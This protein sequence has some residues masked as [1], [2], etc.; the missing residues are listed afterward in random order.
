MIR[1]AVADDDLLVREGIRHALGDEAD[2]DIVAVAADRDELL[3][4]VERESPD[5]VLTDIRMPP[6]HATEGIDIARILRTSHPGTGVIVVSLYA[7]PEYALALLES[8]AARRGYL[9]KDRLANRQQLVAAI[10]LVAAGGSAV[11][12]QVVEILVRRGSRRHGSL[13]QTLSPREHEILAEIAAGRSNR[14]IADR[15]FLSKGAVEQHVSAVFAKL[16]LPREAEVSRRVVATLLFLA[17]GQTSTA[18]V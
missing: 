6:G 18:Q 11:D 2:I 12:P 5:L 8:G 3:D 14:A 13:L 1:L 17:D 16:E 15:L 7:H 4:A 10:K 9:L